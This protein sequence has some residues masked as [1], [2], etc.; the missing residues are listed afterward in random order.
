MTDLNRMKVRKIAADEHARE[1]RDRHGQDAGS[2]LALGTQTP[3]SMK[4]R[5]EAE[6]LWRTLTD[7]MV[8]EDGFVV[9]Q[10]SVSSEFYST[11]TRT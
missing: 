11:F 2:G 6:D 5:L 8:S 1:A 7:I 10:R 9:I 3:Y 4:C